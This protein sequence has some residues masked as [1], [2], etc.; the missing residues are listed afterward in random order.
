[1]TVSAGG[2]RS[3][4]VPAVA[5]VVVNHDA[6]SA[7]RDCV[8]SLVADGVEEIVVVD[9]ASSDDSLDVMAGACADVAVVSTGSNLGYGAGVNRG[10]AAS[11]AEFVL[12][13]NPDVVVEAGA[14]ATL[15]AAVAADPAVAIVG[16]QVLRRDGVR[17]PSARRFPGLVDAVGHAALALF[18]P[19]NPFSRR[20]RMDTIGLA[21]PSAVDWVSG[22]CMLVRRRA[23][24][25]LGGFDE[26]YFMYAEDMDL[27]WRARR[28][29][30]QVVFVPAAAVTHLQGVSTAHHPFRMLV[31]H[32]RSAFR[33][34]ARS[35]RG[36]RRALLPL[37]GVALTARLAAAGV[38]LAFRRR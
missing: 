19:Q 37:V 29:G 36:W 4:G 35:A 11:A 18:W 31:A 22:A 34:V 8:A 2:R 16:P 17:Y 25:E 38:Q 9:N 24:E 32:H 3:P 21:A 27:C 10:V 28:A 15:A 12:V 6:G 14:T 20:Y 1:M 33:F 5:A 26:A 13:T 30:W 23:F 7:L